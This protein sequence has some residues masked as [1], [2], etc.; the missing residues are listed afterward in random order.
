MANK[1]KVFILD[2]RLRDLATPIQL[3]YASAVEKYGSIRKAARELGVHFSMVHDAVARLEKAAAARGYAP[4]FDLTHPTAPGQLLKGTS[5]FY[6]RDGKLRSQWVKTDADQEFR[7]RLMK[8]ACAAMAKELPR[9]KPLAPPIAGSTMSQL[10]NVYTLT[11]CHVGM[12]AW[13]KEN[14]DADGDWDLETAEAVLAGCFE[15][16]VT[17]SPRASVGIVAQLGD[18]LHSDGL[19]A[20]TPLHGHLLDQDGRFPKVVQAAVRILRRVVNFALAHHDKVVVLMAEGNHDLASSV[21][22]RVTVIQSELPY[23]VHQH[24]KTMLA[25]HHGHLKKPEEL[26]LLFAAQ[27]PVVW[28]TTIKRYAHCGHR[29]HVDEHEHAGITVTQHPTL[30]SRDAFASRGGWMAERQCTAITYHSQYGQVGRVTV[31][32]EMLKS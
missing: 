17:S 26:P 16:M 19:K 8:E 5:T 12:L 3:K 15:L 1:P 9:L 20:V 28:G 31:T 6:D 24:G 11:D 13:H 23:Y 4:D 18:F 30:A 2:D 14:M 29:H 21:W 10:A 32:P 25:W 22:L 7:D 27:F